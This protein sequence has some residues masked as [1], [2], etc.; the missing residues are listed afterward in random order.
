[1]RGEGSRQGEK[2]ARVVAVVVGT[3][4]FDNK[5]PPLFD[6]GTFGFLQFPRGLAPAGPL[7]RAD[8]RADGRAGTPFL[9]KFC[10]LVFEFWDLVWGLYRPLE[11]SHFLRRDFS[12]GMHLKSCLGRPLGPEL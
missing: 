12:R 8:E 1:M 4:Q 6:K 7:A 3:V 10:F 9:G 5:K 11:V 2:A